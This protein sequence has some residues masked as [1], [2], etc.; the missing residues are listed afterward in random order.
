M[1]TNKFDRNK[2]A[3]GRNYGCGF[4]FLKKLK[5]GNFKTLMPF[6]ACKDYLND[7]VYVET[8]NKPLSIIYGFKHDYTGILNKKKYFYLGFKAVH[9]KGGDIWNNFDEFQ[10]LTQNNYNNL[11]L[12]LNKLEVLFKIKSKTKLEYI[13]DNTIILKVPIFWSKFTFLISL[14]TLYIRCFMSITDEDL[15]KDI[16]ILINEY[17]KFPIKADNMLYQ[18][19]KILFT[20]KTIFDNLLKYEYP[21]NCN[22]GFI[23]NFGISGRIQQLDK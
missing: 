16:S 20:N 7:F 17:S 2:L 14:Y 1:I 15:K 4:S 23:H 8:T 19:S 3:E 10:N 6:T 18:G 13:E 11:I 12:F 22:S 5:K 21:N 9:Y